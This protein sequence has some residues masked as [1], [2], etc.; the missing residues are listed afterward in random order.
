MV[1]LLKEET[2]REHQKLWDG[3]QACRQA[4]EFLTE[5]KVSTTKYLLG[6]DRK[7]IRIMVGVLTGHNNLRYHLNKMGLSDDPNCRRC[8]DVPETAKHFLCHCPALYS[9]RAKWLGEFYVTLEDFGKVPLT[10][11]LSFVTESKW[12]DALP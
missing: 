8:G 9:L 7:S 4:K 12:L 1:R 2:G 10:R 5:C 6:L 11:V 3:L